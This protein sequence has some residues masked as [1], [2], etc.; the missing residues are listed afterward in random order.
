MPHNNRMETHCSRPIRTTA[1]CISRR[2]G[3]LWSV[4]VGLHYRALATAV[5]DDLCVVL[6]RLARR[7]RQAG[8]TKAGSQAAAA[9]EPRQ[10]DSQ[11]HATFSRGARLTGHVMPIRNQ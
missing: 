11:E 9:D 1:R 8:R 2:S 7:V 4:R 3:A 6:D 5:G 10:A